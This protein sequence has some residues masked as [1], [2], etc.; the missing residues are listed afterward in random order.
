MTQ[1]I[2]IGP[3]NF[4]GVSIDDVLGKQQGGLSEMCILLY[5]E[6]KIFRHDINQ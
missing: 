2:I 4:T 3:D 6:V 5:F 1:P